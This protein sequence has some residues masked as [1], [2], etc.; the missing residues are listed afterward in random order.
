MNK[1][2]IR[3]A[4]YWAWLLLGSS[5]IMWTDLNPLLL[6]GPY[7]R[8][9]NTPHNYV[10]YAWIAASFMAAATIDLGRVMLKIEPLYID[11]YPVG[12]NHLT[13]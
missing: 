2:Q 11:N 6:W 12:R 5:A 4:L 10:M 13:P 9:V 1:D 8:W 3:L 7:F